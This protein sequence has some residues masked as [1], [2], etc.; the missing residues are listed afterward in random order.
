MILKCLSSSPQHSKT[1]KKKSSQSICH[2]VAPFFAQNLAVYK[3]SAYNR[4][5]STNG[6]E[7]LHIYI[8]TISFSFLQWNKLLKTASVD[9]FFPSALSLNQHKSKKALLHVQ[10]GVKGDP[11]AGRHHNCPPA[12][13]CEIIADCF[14]VTWLAYQS[15]TI[16]TQ[17]KQKQGRADKQVLESSSGK[18]CERRVLRMETWFWCSKQWIQCISCASATIFASS[19]QARGLQ[20]S[21]YADSQVTEN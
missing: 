8:H 2:T 21:K 9:T 5:Y 7:G 6:S 16:P 11:K 19:Q 3:A 20:E 4:M 18:L 15:T 10:Q 17:W 13:V 1:W 14:H 12:P